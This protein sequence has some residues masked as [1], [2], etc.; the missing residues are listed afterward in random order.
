MYGCI[1]LPRKNFKGNWDLYFSYLCTDLV[2]PCKRNVNVQGVVE[3]LRVFAGVY[4]KYCKLIIDA[5]EGVDWN[6]VND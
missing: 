6:L 2:Q 1:K 5:V 3:T 4:E